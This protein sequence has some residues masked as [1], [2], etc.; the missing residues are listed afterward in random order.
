MGDFLK[1]LLGT[2]TAPTGTTDRDSRA[3]SAEA[4]LSPVMRAYRRRFHQ[5]GAQP[6]GLFWS[7]QKNVRTRFEALV[8]IFDE[9]DVKAGETTVNDLGCGYGA[10]FEYLQS[11][12]ALRGGRYY[13][14]DMC[15]A[16]V[17]ECHKRIRDPRATFEQASAAT[18]DA[19]YSFVSGTY[20]LKLA[21]DDRAWL[22]YVFRSLSEL[23]DRTGKG[24][25]FNMLDRR[26]YQFDDGLFYAERATFETFCRAALSP[27]VQVLTDYG[28]PDFTIYVR[29]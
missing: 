16:L 25:A 23:W 12:P 24:L 1:S 3:T 17:D 18:R 6:K 29:R 14:Y 27:D 21:A 4:L 15:E 2:R 10:L 9:A 7:S 8:G 19:D 28:V 13:G 22:D 11:H 5:F 20:N 26:Y